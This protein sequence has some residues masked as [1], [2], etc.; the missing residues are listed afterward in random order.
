MQLYCQLEV[1]FPEALQTEIIFYSP[2]TPHHSP[3]FWFMFGLGCPYVR[4]TLPWVATHMASLAFSWVRNLG[5]K[6]E[7]KTLCPDHAGT[8]QPLKQK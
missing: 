3:P 4:V 7:G 5:S 1:G 2:I 8:Q 6:C